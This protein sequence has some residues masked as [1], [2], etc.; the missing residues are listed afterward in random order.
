MT[1][2]KKLK[3]T[4]VRSPA[5]R[6][7]AHRACVSGLGL[8]KLRHSVVVADTRENRGMIHRVAYLL[9]VEEA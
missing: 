2:A 7:G 9:Q 3:V 8:R 5:G 4:L 1:K 6:I